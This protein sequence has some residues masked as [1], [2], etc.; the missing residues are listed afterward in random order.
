MNNTERHINIVS[1]DIPYPPDYGGVIDVF[2]K[3]KALSEIGVRVHLHCFQYGRDFSPEL[4]ALCE[5]VTYYR[6]RGFFSSLFFS[7][8]HI[9]SSRRSVPLLRNLLK[10]D[11]PV[12]FEGLH[13]TFYLQHPKLSQRLRIVR[14]H[15]IEFIYY[16]HLAKVEKKLLKRLYFKKE[17]A[18]LKKYQKILQSASMIAAISPF[19]NRIMQLKYGN[20]FYLPVFHSSE[21]LCSRPGSG[22]FIL[23]HGNLGIG[24]NN[25][26]AL[27]L[28]REVF[29][30]ISHK[31]VIAGSN[32]SVMLQKLCAYYSN[33][34]L[35]KPANDEIY[36]LIED[37]HINILPTFQNTGIKLKLLNA[38]FRGRFCIVNSK[39]VKDT[40]ME[41]L[42]IIAERGD[43][44]VEAINKCFNMEFNSELISIR[45]DTLEKDFNNKSNARLLCSK[46]FDTT[47]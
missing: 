27:F 20:S 22:D 15:N 38:L 40:G 29:S 41:H 13:T 31:V 24:E 14:M 33:I 30:K 25:E 6:R 23:Y 35:V 19:E 7:E 34:E 3:I 36:R 44:F 5:D 17:S 9:V 39:M 18:K 12:L 2:F 47:S 37:A 43:E 4:E 45:K 21:T 11:Y 32:P 10:N 28:V 46:F 42:C 8:P 1:F 16:M 26:A